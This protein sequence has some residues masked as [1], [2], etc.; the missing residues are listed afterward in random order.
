MKNTQT[1]NLAQ[2]A[3]YQAIKT[4]LQ[5]DIQEVYFHHARKAGVNTL[6]KTIEK[7]LQELK[8]QDL[9]PET[10]K[11]EV[12]KTKLPRKL[13]KK[14]K[15]QNRYCFDIIKFDSIESLNIEMRL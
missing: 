9:L 10:I 5:N 4:K 12:C 6:K 11:F 1:M 14:F 2:Y 7:Y 13:K 8:N 15:K 3:L